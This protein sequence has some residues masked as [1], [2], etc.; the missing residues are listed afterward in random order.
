M[1]EHGQDPSGHEPGTPSERSAIEPYPEHDD[2]PEAGSGS[3]GRVIAAV[4]IGAVI[5]ILVVLHLTGAMS[6]HGA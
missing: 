4:V 1:P 5:L 3:R 2:R 6:P